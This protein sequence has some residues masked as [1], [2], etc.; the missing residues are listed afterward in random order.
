MRS[1]FIFGAIAIFMHGCVSEDHFGKSN[2]SEIK[3]FVIPGQSGISVINNDSLTVVVTIPETMT[4]FM[5]V[6]LKKSP[7]KLDVAR[8]VI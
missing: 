1:I 8:M 7:S 2:R 6:P 5:L 3:T 4:D